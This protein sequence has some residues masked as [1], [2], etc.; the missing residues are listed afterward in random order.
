MRGSIRIGVALLLPLAAAAACAREAPP[1]D[2]PVAAAAAAATEPPGEPLFDGATLAGWS[3][4][5]SWWSVEDGCIVGRSTAEHPLERST[6]LFWEGEAQ[7]FVLDFDYRI[8]GGNSGIQYRSVRLPDGDVAGYQAD[9][10]D[11]PNY[12]G[13]LYESGGRGIV[14]QRGERLTLAHDGARAAGETL[15]SAEELQARV[16]AGEWNHYRV[17]ARGTRLTHEINGA[18]MVEVVDEE[19]GRARAR[20]TFALQLHQ[21]PPMEVRFRDLRLRRLPLEGAPEAEWIWS[22]ATAGAGEERW[23]LRE[24]DLAAPATLTGG[25]IAA[26]NRFEAWLDGAPFASGDDWAQP[27]SAPAGVELAAGTHLLATRCANDGGPAALALRLHLRAAD[28]AKQ[29]LVSDR[30]W[31]AFDAEPPGWRDAPRM[32]PGGSPA[33]SFGRV[34]DHRGPW[35]A[36]M[37]E[38]VAT[39]AESLTVPAGFAVELMHSATPAQGSWVA[40]TFGPAGEIFV[41]PQQGPLQVLRFPGG[42]GAPPEVEILD[43]PC[44]SAQGLLWAHGA[45]W[46]NAQGGPDG[47]LHRLRDA[48]GDGRLET[49]EVILRY[50][51]PGEHGAHGIV[52]GPDGGLYVVLGNHVPLPEG[53]SPDSPYRD[54]GEDVLLER[55]WDPRGHAVG[56]MAP[57][58]TVLRVSPD[59]SR[60]DL[61]YAGLRNSYDLAFA[62][63]GEL[64]TY[65]ADMEWDLGAPWY[66]WPRV[67]HVVP[68]G[69]NGWRSGSAKWPSQYP[70]S[71]PAVVDTGPASPTGI[72]FGTG[73]GFPG[74]WREALYIADWAYGRI[75]AVHLEPRGASYAGTTETFVSG[76][77]LNVADL[78]FGPDGALWF[79]TGGRG[80]QSGLYRVRWIGGAQPPPAARPFDAASP[81]LALRRA[82]ERGE[83]D[84]ERARAALTHAD[85]FVRWAARLRLEREGAAAAAAS[86]APE[87]LIARARLG[88]PIAAADLVRAW[89][90]GAR[91]TAVRAAMLAWIRSPERRD[92]LRGGWTG[93]ASERM[94]CGDP[95]LDRELAALLVAV[96][97][98]ELAPRLMQR[99]RA[100]P[101]AEGKLHYATLLRL[102]RSGWDPDLRVEFLS[103]VRSARALPGGYSLAGFWEAIEQAAVA[104]LPD[105]EAAEVMLRVPA[106]PPAA[107][108]AAAEPRPFVRSWSVSEAA[109]ALAGAGAPDLA[110]GARLFA[111]VGC[112]QCH[113][114]DG[115]G[116]SVGP[117]LSAAGAR[118]AR[119]DLLEAVIEPQKVVSD[120]YAIVPMPAGLAD[121]LDARELRDLVGWL[122]ARGGR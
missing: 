3:G 12:S 18:I 48:D 76:K 113:R 62:P 30:A 81:E 92:A 45:L 86:A 121:S 60:W 106:A 82:L 85:R 117:D 108:Y 36:A 7:D 31:I 10:E 17:T 56:V 27:V 84:G 66:R 105:A 69:E 96:E 74:A 94:P 61:V 37:A 67:V 89:D 73:S 49:H 15:G 58:G 110:R 16:R 68:G 26:D 25:A 28:G 104:A 72:V 114:V 102:V 63:N 70:D 42:H 122:E 4:D 120:Q 97:A 1:P 83:A 47:G 78:E 79:V 93:F 2:G 46:V 5:L 109:D 54:G 95:L 98:P 116:G 80:T 53:R 8:A 35:G 13:I 57:G 91:W 24:F 43:L 29:T 90:A 112:V 101:F 33:H 111:A 119:R 71:L 11:G 6:Y 107:Q 64:F 88:A 22:A 9:I 34:G 65:D 50:G 23:L 75:T 103:F 41:S 100:E 19:N 40:M 52:L 14:A 99:M 87:A 38:R 51:P 39:P 20:G 118:F 55:L 32:P 77:P 59:G 44:G 21:G 115:N